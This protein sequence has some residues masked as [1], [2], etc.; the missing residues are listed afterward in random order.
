MSVQIPDYVTGCPEKMDLWRKTEVSTVGTT[1]S[2]TGPIVARN[3][4]QYKRIRKV[5]PLRVTHNDPYDAHV[6]KS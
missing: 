3:T 1:T 2:I 6:T 5:P 4:E